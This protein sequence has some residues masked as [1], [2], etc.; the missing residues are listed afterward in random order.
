[1]EL[2]AYT[3]AYCFAKRNR[4]FK[5]FININYKKGAFRFSRKLA[6]NLN[7]MEYDKVTFYQNPNNKNEWYVKKSNDGFI[8]RKY[9][10]NPEFVFTSLILAKEILS[11][12]DIDFNYNLNFENEPYI[13]DGLEYWKF[14]I[15]HF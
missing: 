10:K 4:P 13:I 1:M 14:I 12:V 6:N 11:I 7:L 9:K 2:I 3:D 8:V 5:L 15:K